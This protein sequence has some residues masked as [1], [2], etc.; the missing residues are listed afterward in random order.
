MEVAEHT[1]LTTPAAT[2]ISDVRLEK[3]G[4]HTIQD[5]KNILVARG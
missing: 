3:A 1:L 2:I 5:D 4:R